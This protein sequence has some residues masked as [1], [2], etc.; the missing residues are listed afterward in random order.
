M[1]TA[2]SL[3]APT[4]KLLI[5]F[6]VFCAISVIVS[7]CLAFIAVIRPWPDKEAYL[8][9]AT[10]VGSAPAMVTALA[11]LATHAFKGDI[12]KFLTNR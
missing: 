7:T 8:N 11:G 3:E 6:S 10:A 1:N 5:A 12:H 9:L 2:K 4:L